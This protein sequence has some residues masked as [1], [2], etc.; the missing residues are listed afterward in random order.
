MIDLSGR[1]AIVTGGASGIGS[2]ICRVLAEQGADVV[3]ADINVGGAEPVAKEIEAMGR[4]S[5]AVRLDVTDPGSVSS[6]V[7]QVIDEFGKIDILVNDAGVV[8]AP[9]WWERSAPNSDDWDLV[10]AV[11]LRGLVNQH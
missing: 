9:D 11:N 2:G 6:V 8:G 3:V 5:S 10:M 1:L 7:A 4:K